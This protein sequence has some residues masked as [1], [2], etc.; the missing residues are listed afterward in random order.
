VHCV[1]VAIS[2]ERGQNITRRSVGISARSIAGL[3]YWSP[4]INILRDPRWGR[5]E[6]YGETPVS[7]PAWG[8]VA[9]V[10]GLQG[11]DS[12][13][14]KAGG[15]PQTPGRPQRARVEPPLLRCPRQR[16]RPARD[17]SARLSRRASRDGKAASVMAALT[18]QRRA[19]L[20]QPGR[21]AGNSAREVGVDGYVTS[22]CGAIDDI[23]AHHHVVSTAEEAV[24]LAVNSRLRARMRLC[25]SG[26]CWPPWSRG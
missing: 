18:R 16:A 21:A 3:T 24:A 14:F 26:R 23:Y 22:D 20:R 11:D 13:L 6:T 7:R 25:L 17:L 1:A 19:G 4:N 8:P 10:K 5:A 12:A 9:F 15:D 2:D